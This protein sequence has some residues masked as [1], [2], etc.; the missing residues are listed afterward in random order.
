MVRLARVLS[1]ALVVALAAT[2]VSRVEAFGCSVSVPVSHTTFGTP[3]GGGFL[4][5]Q[6]TQELFGPRIRYW[7]FPQ[8]MKANS[9]SQAQFNPE[10]IWLANVSQ[11]IAQGG[12]DA[13]AYDPD[14]YVLYQADWF[15]NGV[16]GC[17]KEIE[18]KR[19][20]VEM[21]YGVGS[22]TTQHYT[23][24]II[25]S[26][27]YAN[28]FSNFNFDRVIDGNA[29]GAFIKAVPIPAP[30]VAGAGT[31]NASDGS[32][33]DVTL[34]LTQAK[35]YGDAGHPNLIAGYQLFY[36]NDSAPQSNAPQDY[37]PV[38]DPS[39]PR[40]PLPLIAYGTEAVKV[41]VPMPK[42]GSYFVTQLVYTDAT[43]RVLSNGVSGNSGMA[44]SPGGTEEET[45]DEQEVAENDSS[46]DDADGSGDDAEAEATP[47][48]TDEATAGAIEKDLGTMRDMGLL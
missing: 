27:A 42:S 8:F 17:V 32:Y 41:T 4:I 16:S 38:G 44:A 37:R 24:Y 36:L 9:G 34:K 19:T 40:S 33:M 5:P 30:A 20:V 13:G 22:G 21:T 7:G 6:R 3:T 11:L 18:P 23:A 28:Q 29:G 45:E 26:V 48:E 12:G 35:S 46:G 14:H 1:L 10:T 39:S 43:T 15:G 47:Q 25:A 2:D 31:K